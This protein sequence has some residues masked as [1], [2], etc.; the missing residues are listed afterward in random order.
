VSAFYQLLLFAELGPGRRIVTQGIIAV[1]MKQAVRQE[2]G[3]A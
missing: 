1:A 2:A 3:G